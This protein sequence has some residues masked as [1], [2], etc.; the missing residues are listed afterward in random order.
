MT[1]TNLT[2]TQHEAEVLGNLV[3]GMSAEHFTSYMEINGVLWDEAQRACIRAM[4]RFANLATQDELD[5]AIEAWERNSDRI[6]GGDEVLP[7]LTRELYARADAM[8]EV[9]MCDETLAEV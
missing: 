5:E 8:Y 2:A 3:R 1:C 7:E 4:H 9:A 6:L